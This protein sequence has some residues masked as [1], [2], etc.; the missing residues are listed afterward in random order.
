MSAATRC[1]ELSYTDSLLP[2]T[3][4]ARRGSTGG[5]VSSETSTS[6]H[7]IPAA[8]SQVARLRGSASSW[9]CRPGTVYTGDFSGMV[10]RVGVHVVEEPDRLGPPAVH[11][12]VEDV[13]AG[14]M[15]SGIEGQP[16]LGD[17]PER[18][19][20]HDQAFAVRDRVDQPSPLRAGN[21]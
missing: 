11:R 5:S 9:C 15:A 19:V 21:A 10:G 16:F 4:K 20:G 3:T 1:T 14:V 17:L 12:A 13:W 2:R 8:S 7:G 6:C 18:Y